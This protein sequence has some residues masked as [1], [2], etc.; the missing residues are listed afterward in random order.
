MHATYTKWATPWT[1]LGLGPTMSVA[2][3]QHVQARVNTQVTRTTLTTAFSGSRQVTMTCLGGLGSFNIALTN[4]SPSPR[5]PPVRKTVLGFMLLVFSCSSVKIP[6]KYRTWMK[7][8]YPLSHC[9]YIGRCESRCESKCVQNPAGTH[10]DSPLLD[11]NAL[12]NMNANWNKLCRP[13]W[14]GR[15]SDNNKHDG[16]WLVHS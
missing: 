11:I 3:W 10:L 1:V 2:T 4:W 16:C 5:L 7:H 15:L 12:K 14:T 6:W 9:E 13:V 8:M